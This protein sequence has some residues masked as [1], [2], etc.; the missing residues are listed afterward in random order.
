MRALLDAP[1]TNISAEFSNRSVRQ[2]HLTRAQTCLQPKSSL[3]FSRSEMPS[4]D[5]AMTED[6]SPAA[7]PIVNHAFIINQKRKLHDK[8]VH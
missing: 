3:V 8:L 2:S 7:P 6:G 1:R 5:L 4:K